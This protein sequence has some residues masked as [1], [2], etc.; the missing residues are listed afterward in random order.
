MISVNMV[1]HYTKAVVLSREPKGEI[2][3]IL[4][5]YT[6]DL[7]KIVAKA[8]SIR[9]ITSKLSGHLT[10]GSIAKVR[11]VEMNGNGH[12]LIDAL[13]THSRVAVDSLRFL[14]FVNKLTPIGVS[15]QRLWRELEEALSENTISKATYHRVISVTGY[16][17]RNASC[18]NCHTTQIAYFA[19]RD[20]MFLCNRC[21]CE[22]SLKEDEVFSI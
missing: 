8:K 21:F 18:D 19:P 3:A 14:D 7:G 2:D 16:N 5:L 1:E 11:I 12:Q 13:S 9:R 4:T 10:L 17:T 20:I 6:K 15:D 22:S